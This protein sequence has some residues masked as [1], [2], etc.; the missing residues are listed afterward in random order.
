MRKFQ[1]L[2]DFAQVLELE[3]PSDRQMRKTIREIGS[4]ATER[5]FDGWQE[6]SRELA[7][8]VAGVI[9]K[10][11]ETINQRAIQDKGLQVSIDGQYDSPGHTSTNGKV[12]VI[13]CETKLALAG[14]AKSKNDPGIG[15]SIKI[16]TLYK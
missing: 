7:V 3:I 5:V 10:K 11:S 15:I 4:I 16:N 6:I 8:N 14:V 2:C 1:R 13:D 12:T 9:E